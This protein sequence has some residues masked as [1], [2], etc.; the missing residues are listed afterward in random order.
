[1]VPDDPRFQLQCI[2]SGSRYLLQYPMEL[3]LLRPHYMDDESMLGYKSIGSYDHCPERARVNVSAVALRKTDILDPN[4]HS[5]RQTTKE[6][7]VQT[8]PSARGLVG[9]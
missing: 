4:E 8:Y 9:F 2:A 1:M 3:A 6:Q 5:W 7:Y